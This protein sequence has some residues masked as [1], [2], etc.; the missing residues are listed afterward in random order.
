MEKCATIIGYY[1]HIYNRKLTDWERKLIEDSFQKQVFKKKEIIF[2]S[3]ETNTR[4]YFVEKGL[5][6]MYVID[7]TGKE[8]NILF[9][10]ENQWIGDLSSPDETLFFLDA[11]EKSTVYSIS[12]ENVN[13]L[14]NNFSLFVKYLKR[15][16]IF[17]QKRLISILSKTAEENYVELIESHPE[18]VK[19]LPQYHISSYLGV[20]SVFLSKVLSKRARKKD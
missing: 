2:T 14:T 20:T 4:H 9:A 6:R 8:F 3:G 11:I 1:E 10:S 13:L 18:L 5:L 16:Y 17:L 12:D 19:R 15:S 7:A